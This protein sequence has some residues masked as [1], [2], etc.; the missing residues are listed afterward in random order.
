MTKHPQHPPAPKGGRATRSQRRGR[1]DVCFFGET[2]PV[3]IQ[4]FPQCSHG[5]HGLQRGRGTCLP[6]LLLLL[7]LLRGLNRGGGGGG[8]KGVELFPP[9]KKKEEE[10]KKR[11][12]S[13][14]LLFPHPSFLRS[15]R[16]RGRAWL[17]SRAS[18]AWSAT[19][20]SR[21]R[22]ATT[23]TPTRASGSRAS[24]SPWP[25]TTSRNSQSL[26]VR[27]RRSRR[28]WTARSFCSTFSRC[29]VVVVGVV[30]GGVVWPIRDLTL[31][32]TA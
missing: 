21:P 5:H 32:P 30:V 13:I 4:K 29:V 6:V 25:P 1:G 12:A 3:K 10:E 15:G 16:S 11:R 22:A 7:L 26:W 20:R 31:L 9:C 24:H 8:G 2:E 23:A 19:A 14:P 27:A 18:T 28:R 17:R